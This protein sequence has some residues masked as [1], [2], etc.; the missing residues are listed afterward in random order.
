MVPHALLTPPTPAPGAP[1]LDGL[2]AWAQ[3][4]LRPHGQGTSM[5][6]AWLQ[7]LAKRLGASQAVLAWY[8]RGHTCIAAHWAPG[9]VL[10]PS[11]D[12][13]L[14][15]ALDEATDEGQCLHIGPDVHSNG[16]AGIT[17]ALGAALRALQDA[18]G[19][20]MS[21]PLP[22]A[23]V[24]LGALLMVWSPG[25]P[26]PADAA[27]TLEHAARAMAPLLCLQ[28]LAQRPWHW[29]VRQA[30]KCQWQRWRH[31]PDAATRRW[32]TALLVAIALLLVLPFPHKLG[33]QARI[34]GLQQRVLS[35]PTDGYIKATHALPGDHVKQGTVLLDLVEQD[36]KLERDKWLS[37][38]SQFDN[39][40]AAAMTRGDRAEASI[41][42][43]RLEEAQAQLALVDQHLQRAQLRAPFDGVVIQ[44]DLSQSIGAPVKQGDAL[45][46]VASENGHRL[47][48]D[49]DEGDIGLIKPGQQGSMAL[50][51]LPWQ[52][53]PF[54]VRRITPQ[55]TARDGL[56]VY[57][58]EAAFTEALPPGTRPGLMG[59]AKVRV[60]YSPLAWS[61]VRPLVDKTRLWLWGWG[62]GA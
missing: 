57:E 33:G 59:P 60:G 16:A 25:N 18:G 42:L 20:A 34:E 23:D 51:A 56:N 17:R 62:W 46:T 13:L 15:N 58:V 55:A 52:T 39:A 9:M 50:S 29:H 48:I 49:I 27:A 38:A 3:G 31:P 4:A 40:Y 1:A 30:I 2:E 5:E 43:S 53:L 8:E 32:R 21:L 44:G 11:L 6:S 7:A 24:P 54:T 35:A 26:P 12:E 41:S 61:W 10:T 45:M 36:L 47:I 19:A 14:R 37:Q 28:R 22:G